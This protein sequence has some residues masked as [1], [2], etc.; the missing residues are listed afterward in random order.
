MPDQ[1]NRTAK[2]NLAFAKIVANPTDISWSQV[3]NAGSLFACLSL[4]LK[5][6]NSEISLQSV[7]RDIF[8][9]LEAEFFS[10]E[11]KNLQTIKEASQVSLSKVPEHVIENLCLAYFKDN[12]LYLILHG[13]GKIEI[14]RG[15]KTGTLLEKTHHSKEGTT[16]SGRL[17]HGDIIL[18]QTPQF[19]Q[20]I[21]AAI[22]Q[23]AFELSLPS[24]IAETLSPHIHEKEE[25][26]AA[27]IIIS[28]QGV[29]GHPQA[30]IAEP[31]Q[32]EA[33]II[34]HHQAIYAQTSP[35]DEPEDAIETEEDKPRKKFKITLPS[36]A[37]FSKLKLIKNPF[38]SLKLNHL[39]KI[40]LSVVVILVIVLGV[41]IF[42][43]KKKQQSAKTSA[44]FQQT[45]PSAKK[46]YD[47][48]TA[49]Q[50][51]NADLAHDDFTK[52]DKTIKDKLDQFPEGSTEK[53]QLQ[54][55]LSQVDAQLGGTATQ[56][57]P[58]NKISIKEA[59]V[60]SN[61][62]LNEEKS[63]GIIAAAQ[64]NSSIYTLSSKTITKTDKN[65]GQK[66]DIIKNDNTWTSPQ[67]LAPYQGNIYVLDK[68]KGILKFVAGSG[69]YGESNY[70]KD[71]AP[72]VS[73]AQ[74]IAIDSSIY[75]LLQDGTIQKYTRGTADTFKVQ[76]LTL[77]F[78]TPTKIFTAIDVDNIYVLDN[79]NSRIVKLDKDGN[80]QTEYDNDQ[81]KQAQDF[82]VDEKNKTIRFLSSGK[83]W[84]INM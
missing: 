22:I 50:K 66:T 38:S 11:E 9:N 32:E 34:E 47:E 65:T 31:N 51:L 59:S 53:Q 75:V 64:D 40:I 19:V 71:P 15:E 61:D 56:V 24:D 76:G 58:P 2:Q 35:L 73:K 1:L 69:G 46:Y 42:M 33:P 80:Y 55:L 21:P 79:G 77:P 6:P 78:A 45:Y 54:A 29:S 27:A 17:N 8:N 60:G 57:T 23:K 84:Q 12:I 68:A 30:I 28:Y 20:S 26:G 81:I 39:Q 16:A 52:A 14:K 4:S 43:T 67:S 72:D 37:I 25:G 62:L 13:A 44:L 70:F 83:I 36:F 41:S 10:L 63:P 18:L 7:G 48:G 49:L 5:E 82:E 74:A 3:Y